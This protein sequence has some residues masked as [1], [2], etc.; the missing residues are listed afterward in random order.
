MIPID[1]SVDTPQPHH[2][3]TH[4]ILKSTICLKLHDGVLKAVIILLVPV[5]NVLYRNIAMISINIIA[6]C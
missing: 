6:E 2:V 3:H 4:T 1:H 5:W